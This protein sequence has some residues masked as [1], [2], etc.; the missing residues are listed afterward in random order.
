M[1]NK[2][3]GSENII[4]QRYFKINYYNPLCVKSYDL[5]DTIRECAQ[6]IDN[7]L[8][9]KT[10]VYLEIFSS[11]YFDTV[12]QME[13]YFSNPYNRAK[14]RM[15]EGIVVR[16]NTEHS[17]FWD[18]NAPKELDYRFNDGELG[19]ELTSSDSVEYKFAF[20]DYG[21]DFQNNNKAKELCSTVWTGVY[22][23]YIRNSID[24]SNKRGRME[25]EDLTRLSFEQ[26]LLYKLV[27]GRQDL[28][29]IIIKNI[30]Q[31]CS[32]QDDDWYE[33]SDV[34]N[35]SNGQKTEYNNVLSS[36]KEKTP[37]RMRKSKAT[38]KK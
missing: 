23:K 34:Y 14:M 20:Y 4:C 18:G 13:K 16:E 27:E 30:C 6:M 12:E 31:T 11:K 37:S 35:G 24:L 38:S 36:F 22:P 8:K 15:G 28:V 21:P 17:Y 19:N 25:G 32:Q 29:Y 5:V 1:K 9:E 26:Y 10:L 2:D 7:D 3:D 33:T